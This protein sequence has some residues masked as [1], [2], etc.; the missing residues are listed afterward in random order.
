[1]DLQGETDEPTVTVGDFTPLYQK[2]TGPAGRRQV[3]TQ[4]DSTTPAI[5][6]IY[7]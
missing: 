2:W 3:R 7:L 5:N 4:L 1:M 6:W